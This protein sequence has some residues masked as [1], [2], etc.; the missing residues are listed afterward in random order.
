VRLDPA[1]HATRLLSSL[2]TTAYDCE[3]SVNSYRESLVIADRHPSPPATTIYFR[4]EVFASLV[5][6]YLKVPVAMILFVPGLV[7]AFVFLITFGNETVI[8]LL[9]QKQARTR[10]QKMLCGL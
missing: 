6:L 2:P 7:L 9:K 5:C 10:T 1:P 4:P 3:N 8:A